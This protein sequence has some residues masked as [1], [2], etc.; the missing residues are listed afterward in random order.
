MDTASLINSEQYPA[1]VIDGSGSSVFAGVLR[2]DGQ[3]LA[4]SEQTGAALE[5]LFPTVESVLKDA[6]LSLGDLRSYIYCEGPGSVLGLRLCAMAIE[7]WSRLY[8][9]SAR[10]FAYNTLQLCAT[11]LKKDTSLPDLSLIISDWKKGAWNAVYIAEGD[12]GQT[13]VADDPTIAEWQGALYHLPQ[14]KG[15]QLPPANVETLNYSPER[16][17]EVMQQPGLLRPTSGVEL[18]ASGINTFAKWAPDRHRAP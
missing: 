11:L 14:R 2:N 16:L 4:H 15:W 8:P 13:C 5:M 6:E 1:L 17:P 3:W 12:I 18:Y 7:T 9:E 10:T